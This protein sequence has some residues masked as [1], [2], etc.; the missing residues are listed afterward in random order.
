M[1]PGGIVVEVST[2]PDI[3]A[4]HAD[5]ARIITQAQ[6]HGDGRRAGAQ[7]IDGA[8]CGSGGAPDGATGRQ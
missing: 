3:A 1:R 7:A 8:P 5:A 6:E 4:V 2:D